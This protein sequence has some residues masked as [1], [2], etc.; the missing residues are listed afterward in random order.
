MIWYLILFVMNA[1]FNTCL[2]LLIIVL[3]MAPFLLICTSLQIWFG[4]KYLFLQ[5]FFLTKCVFAL[6]GFSVCICVFITFVRIKTKLWNSVLIVGL[7]LVENQVED[8]G[9][10]VDEGEGEGE[11]ASV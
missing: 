3:V 8:V 5:Y 9:V 2:L 4:K 7:M 1:F 11:G 6:T 10:G